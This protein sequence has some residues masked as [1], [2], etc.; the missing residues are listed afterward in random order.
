[1]IYLFFSIII[2]SPLLFIIARNLIKGFKQKENISDLL[3]KNR[4]CLFILICAVL[5]LTFAR[6]KF[7]ID[8]GI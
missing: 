6:V 1:M 5:G 7:F 8:Y 3:V 2:L 4:I